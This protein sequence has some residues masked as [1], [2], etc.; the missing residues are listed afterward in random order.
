MRLKRIVIALVGLGILSASLDWA[1]RAGA[2]VASS[3]N[4]RITGQIGTLDPSSPPRTAG[5][6][7]SYL[8]H[9]GNPLLPG[10]YIHPYYQRAAPAI[11]LL[12]AALAMRGTV[13][14]V[15]QPTGSVGTIGFND[16]KGLTEGGAP[17]P[18]G[19]S[20]PNYYHSGY[21]GGAHVY[22]FRSTT[23]EWIIGLSDGNLGGDVT[24]SKVAIASSDIPSSL[25]ERVL[26]FEFMINPNLDPTTCHNGTPGIPPAGSVG[27]MTLTISGFTGGPRTLTDSYGAIKAGSS[28]LPYEQYAH[29]EFSYGA[30]PG[31]DDFAGSLV[32]YDVVVDPDN[33]PPLVAGL[34][35][36]PDPHESGAV[37]QLSAEATAVGAGES[38][39]LVEYNIDGGA[40]WTAMEL[41]GAVW[42]G[43]VTARSTPGTTRYC[44]RATDGLLDTSA[45]DEVSSEVANC[46]DA[47]TS[48][49]TSPT[50]AWST[51]PSGFQRNLA[52]LAWTLTFSEAVTGLTASDIEN[53]TGFTSTGCMFGV[54]EISAGVSYSVTVASCT[55][56]SIRPSLKRNTVTDSATNSGPA[57]DVDGSTTVT[58][59]KAGPKYSVGAAIT[60]VPRLGRTIQVKPGVWRGGGSFSYEW[61]SC[62]NKVAQLD[63]GVFVLGAIPSGCTVI[64]GATSRMLVLRSA[65]R[66]TW[67]TVKVTA[68]NGAGSRSM[69]TRSTATTIR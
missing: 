69:Y 64:T 27:C 58:Y 40:I 10:N 65:Q 12:P 37:V 14:L 39:K 2:L 38:V 22:I 51:E 19:S 41:D 35:A 55:D 67:V 42:E 44:L 54:T 61:Y 3:L 13:D 49:S 32:K 68:T 48:D 36:H 60:G 62:T 5:F 17:R 8:R 18:P 53:A 33:Q 16:F 29:S 45:S 28:Q 23:T 46:I 43:S 1:P 15:N 34:A 26:E 30:I 25:G 6:A 50:V 11:T 59:V 47:V 66:G 24:Q 56:G 21:Q 7:L 4:T 31:W 52:T 57:A 20:A 9:I 63:R